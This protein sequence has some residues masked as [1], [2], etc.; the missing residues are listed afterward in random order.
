MVFVNGD[1]KHG[2][3]IN[4]MGRSREFLL[5]GYLL[6]FHETWLGNL[7][8]KWSNKHGKMEGV[9]IAMFTRE[10]VFSMY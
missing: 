1:I 2:Y 5:M 4:R 7:W 9:S 10:L 8:T 6:R 3:N